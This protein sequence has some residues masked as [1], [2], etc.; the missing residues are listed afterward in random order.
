LLLTVPRRAI[1]RAM[2]QQDQPIDA[3]ALQRIARQ[4]HAATSLGTVYRF[5]REL[6]A[7]NLLHAQV[8]ARGRSLWRLSALSEVAPE[9]VAAWLQ[10]WRTFMRDLE[11]IGLAEVQAPGAPPAPPDHPRDNPSTIHE[12]LQALALRLGYRLS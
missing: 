2:L 9:P 10:S 11:S 3:V 1:I 7:V 8:P 12:M 4:H 6:R 5:L